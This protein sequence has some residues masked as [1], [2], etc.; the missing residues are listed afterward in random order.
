MSWGKALLWGTVI[1]AVVIGVLA[2]A[3]FLI[4]S[5]VFG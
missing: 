2:A 1:A 4:Q 5:F 3:Y